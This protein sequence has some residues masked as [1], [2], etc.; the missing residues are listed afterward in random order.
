MN[1]GDGYDVTELANKEIQGYEIA[2]I[3]GDAVQGTA[4]TDK[5]IQVIYTVQMCSIVITYVDRDGNAIADPYVQQIAYGSDYKVK[6]QASKKID[7]Y[8]QAEVIGDP[9]KGTIH[10]D[11]H[12]TVIYDVKNNKK[13]SKK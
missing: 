8:K 1:Q 11:V 12:I 3:R 13:P 4:D 9:D 7:G 10:G 5:V 2:E 6:K